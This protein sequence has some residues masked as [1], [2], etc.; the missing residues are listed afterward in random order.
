MPAQ[1]SYFFFPGSCEL[2]TK[3]LRQKNVGG[4]IV[5]EL[6]AGS[7]ITRRLT[8]GG[9]QGKRFLHFDKFLLQFYRGFQFILCFLRFFTKPWE[10]SVFSVPAT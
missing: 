9:G 7:I 8:S 5:G 2:I 4:Q 3:C 1:L 10:W 6:E